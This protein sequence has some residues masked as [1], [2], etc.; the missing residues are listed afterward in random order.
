MRPCSQLLLR[1]LLAASQSL[2]TS[3][4]STC[5]QRSAAFLD[6]MPRLHHVRT[7]GQLRSVTD[8]MACLGCSDVVLRME[9][10]SA[11]DATAEAKAIDARFGTTAKVQ[12]H[13]G[14][15]SERA[16]VEVYPGPPTGVVQYEGAQNL[17]W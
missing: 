12:Q 1:R 11:S 2:C 15:T 5:D 13:Y 17:A 9:S 6:C 10:Y 3:A 16:P 4:A 7:A 8:F 14:S